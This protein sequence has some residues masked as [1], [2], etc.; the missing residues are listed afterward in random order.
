VGYPNIIIEDLERF[1]LMQSLHNLLFAPFSC[2]K[3]GK[4]SS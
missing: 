2:I 1:N 3:N 4:S